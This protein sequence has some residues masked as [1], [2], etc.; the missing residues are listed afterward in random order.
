MDQLNKLIE[1]LTSISNSLDKVIQVFDWL[2]QTLQTAWNWILTD[3]LAYIKIV[4]DWLVR[5][6]VIAFDFF[7]QAIKNI[8]A[9]V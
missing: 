4:V 7:L 9:K 3:G 5:V 2:W 8:A 6:L 1:T